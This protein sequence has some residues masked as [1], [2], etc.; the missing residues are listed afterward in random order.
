MLIEYID[1]CLYVNI[2]TWCTTNI[3]GPDT[4]FKCAFGHN[5][6]LRCLTCQKYAD[7]SMPGGI[8]FF[9][10]YNLA[11]NCSC[12]TFSRIFFILINCKND[13]TKYLLF[14]DEALCLHESVYSNTVRHIKLKYM[15]TKGNIYDLKSFVFSFKVWINCKRN[16]VSIYY[17]NYLCP[18]LQ[19]S[20]W[21]WTILHKVPFDLWPLAPT[22]LH[23]PV[24][25]QTQMPSVL[26]QNCSFAPRL[27]NV[28]KVICMC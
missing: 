25:R 19:L 21:R 15:K 18:Y 13:R 20:S 5:A 24:V 17:M 3:L 11:L 6:D 8:L 2:S 22:G 23:V 1:D 27:V 28:N 4:A 16:W 14:Y 10:Q 7:M 9:K 26:F 12:K